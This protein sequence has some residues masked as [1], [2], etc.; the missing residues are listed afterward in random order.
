MNFAELREAL[1]ISVK[2]PDE[3]D[4]PQADL[5]MY[6]NEGY[7]DLAGRYEYHQTRQRCTFVTVAGQAKY[8]LP[9]DLT[10]VLRLRDNTHGRKLW[11]TGDRS[12]ADQR[13]PKFQHWP[14]HYTRYR[15]YVELIPTPDADGYV[16]EVFYIALPKLLTLDSDTPILPELWHRGIVLRARWHYFVDKG[17]SAQATEAL[18]MFSVWVSDKPLEIEQESVDID[19]AVEVPELETGL[20]R[21]HSTRFDDG[22]FDFRD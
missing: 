22:L 18:N 11:K 21:H 3:G 15:H 5:G 13:V 4:A 9:P 19:N 10:V 7:R 8:Q 20:Y 16:I 14:R 17:D 6:I 12:I 1:R 2:R